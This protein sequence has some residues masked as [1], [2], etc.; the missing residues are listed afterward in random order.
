MHGFGTAC[1]VV[2]AT[3]FIGSMLALRFLPA[4][5]ATPGSTA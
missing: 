2:S 4:R 5:A 1:L 3:A